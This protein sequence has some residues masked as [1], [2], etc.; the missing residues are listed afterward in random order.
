MKTNI[1]EREELAIVSCA[2]FAQKLN[3]KTVFD[4]SGSLTL[5]AEEINRPGLQLAGYFDHFV[6]ERI[7]VIGNAEN[8]FMKYLPEKIKIKVLDQYFSKQFPC[9]IVCRDLEIDDY[10]IEF[11]KKYDIPLFSTGETTTNLIGALNEYLTDLLAP[12]TILHGV[13]LDISGTGVLIT[14]SAGIGKSETALEL[15]LRGHRLVADDSVIAKV[16]SGTILAKCPQKNRYFMEV[17]GIGIVNVKN[18]F[19]P[20]SVLLEKSIDLIV[21]LVPWEE[22]TEYDRLGDETPVTDIL[23]IGV[24]TM[25]I[26]VSPGRNVPIL[27]E[28]AARKVRLEQFGYNAVDEL[29]NSAFKKEDK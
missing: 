1:L 18:M 14:G 20:G 19:G 2:E 3:L 10:I 27:I 29:I 6:P 9:L 23:G 7:Q 11:A 15:I 4:G 28:T 26:P 22:M 16:K 13:M 5:T 21:N 12:N 24:K 17:R 25:V 8:T